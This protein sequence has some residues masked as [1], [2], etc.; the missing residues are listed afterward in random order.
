MP[1]S[2]DEIRPGVVAYL[3]VSVLM[4]DTRIRYSEHGDSFRNS[5]FVCVQ[6]KGDETLWLELT[7]RE[8]KTQRL[9]L[10]SEWRAG[11]GGLWKKKRQ[12]VHDARKPLIGP[13]SAFADASNGVDIYSNS[14]RPEVLQA[15][16]TEMIGEIGKYGEQTL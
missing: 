1:I 15:G 3:N 2:A 8:E 12:F 14:D 4:K 11:G 5:P 13:A 7:T 16:I 10:L 9:E 6:R